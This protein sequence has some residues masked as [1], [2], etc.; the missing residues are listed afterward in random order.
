MMFT[1]AILT[2]D[3]SVIYF[4]SKILSGNI[5]IYVVVIIVCNGVLSPVEY[6]PV[7]LS[8]GSILQYKTVLKYSSKVQ[9]RIPLSNCTVLRVIIQLNQAQSE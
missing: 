9:L 4:N 7:K 3:G 5:Y 8:C 6:F 1:S 2:T